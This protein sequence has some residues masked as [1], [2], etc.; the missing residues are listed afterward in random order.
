LKNAIE[1]CVVVAVLWTCSLAVC[2]AQQPLQPT[3]QEVKTLKSFLLK[4]M[5]A[6]PEDVDKTIRY[7]LALVDLGG[8]GKREAIVYLA[9]RS[10]CGSGGCLMLI[11]APTVSSFRVISRI[12]VIQLPIRVLGS[13]TEGWSDLGVRVQGGGIQPG[14]E[15]RLSFNGSKYPGNPSISPAKRLNEA[16]VGTVVIPQ[17]SE[18]NYLYE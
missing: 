12:T 16:A 18:G 2:C 6:A 9:G 11:L 17:D 7:S 14:Y 10:I 8:N 15:A 3:S 4:Y 1:A 5:S 13:R